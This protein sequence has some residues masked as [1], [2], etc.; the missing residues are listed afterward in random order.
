MTG[1]TKAARGETGKKTF[2]NRLFIIDKHD[3]NSYLTTNKIAG[4]MRR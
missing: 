1:F 3:K 2:E 4:E